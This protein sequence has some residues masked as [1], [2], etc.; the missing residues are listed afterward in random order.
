MDP[1]TAMCV[2]LFL[3]QQQVFYPPY[4]SHLEPDDVFLFPRLNM[5]LEGQRFSNISNIQAAVSK[6]LN[7]VSK[8]DF[9]KSVQHLYE[10][11]RKSFVDGGNYFE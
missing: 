9:L 7:T 11:S 10:R 8:K 5:A 2:R 4:S 3:A 6:E 1:H